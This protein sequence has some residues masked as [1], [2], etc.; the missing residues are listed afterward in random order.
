MIL[1][2][3]LLVL[4]GAFIGLS[5]GR[6]YMKQR[7]QNAGD[8]L[9]DALLSVLIVFFFTIVLVDRQLKWIDHMRLLMAAAQ[10]HLIDDS[11]STTRS[12]SDQIREM[13]LDQVF[14]RVVTLTLGSFIGY[15]VYRLHRERQKPD[16]KP[17]SPWD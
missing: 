10:K 2:L 7:W 13:E 8:A 1:G 17:P 6:S 11:P 12:L 9:V 3:I 15:S 5:M 14:D 4:I 16:Q